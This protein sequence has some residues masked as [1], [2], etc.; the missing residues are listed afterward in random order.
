MQEVCSSNCYLVSQKLAELSDLQTRIM[1][2]LGKSNY[3]QEQLDTIQVE[4]TY[5][6][7]QYHF[8]R[9]ELDQCA[10]DKHTVETL[11]LKRYLVRRRQLEAWLNEAMENR[12]VDDIPESLQSDLT[13]CIKRVTDELEIVNSCLDSL[14]SKSIA[15]LGGL[16]NWPE[17]AR[18]LIMKLRSHEASVP[19]RHPVDVISLNIP[20]Y[21]DI[22]KYPMDLATIYLKLEQNAYTC[23]EEVVADVRQM[24]GN[25]YLFNHR[26]DPITLICVRLELEFELHV[27]NLVRDLLL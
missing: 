9:R 17:F 11:L 22:V 21:Y 25:C 27:R 3:L 20:E 26:D 16:K 14:Q 23:F 15:Y 6:L 18:R 24:F 10:Q 5:L 8:I 2:E 4:K 1:Y 19:F 13:S 12:I 7:D